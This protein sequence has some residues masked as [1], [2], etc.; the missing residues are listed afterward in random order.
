M[1]DW[2]WLAENSSPITLSSPGTSSSSHAASSS[3]TSY[4]IKT[5]RC[6]VSLNILCPFFSLLGIKLPT[7]DTCCAGFNRPHTCHTCCPFVIC[8]YMIQEALLLMASFLLASDK[9]GDFILSTSPGLFVGHGEKNDD[10]R[11]WDQNPCSGWEAGVVLIS[12]SV[13]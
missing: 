10:C 13:L 7:W 6:V 5:S 3:P 12:S 11:G 2:T 8:M 4:A 1:I 9:C